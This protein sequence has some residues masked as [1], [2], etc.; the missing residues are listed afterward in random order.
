M[1]VENP[2]EVLLDRRPAKVARG[3]VTARVVRSDA[4][5]V[6]CAP[7][8]GDTRHPIGPCRGGRR[9]RFIE[10]GAGDE[11]HRHDDLVQL[12]AGTVVLL[13]FTD[14]RPWI[15]AWEEEA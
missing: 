10:T 11:A 5:G 6:W 14:E 1:A 9:R 8:E 12:P 2:L 7:L 13:V 4:S 3:P 15:T